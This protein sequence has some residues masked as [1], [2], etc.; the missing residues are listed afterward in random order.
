[1]GV[2]AVVAFA[3]L[4]R[5]YSTAPAK[6]L[7]RATVFPALAF[8]GILAL[9]VFDDGI[10]RSLE[11][12]SEEGVYRETFGSHFWIHPL[13]HATAVVALIG[14]SYR[15]LR[16]QKGLDRIRLQRFLSAAGLFLTV[17]I[18]LQLI[19]PMFD[20]WILEKEIVFGYVAFAAY[21]LHVLR[22]YHFHS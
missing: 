12:S 2:G 19:L 4:V 1:M 15:Q 6:T 20:V 8:A 17:C 22:R 5:N 3:L 13:F 9:Y 7:T 14:E 10:I 16:A 11:F 21:A 18:V